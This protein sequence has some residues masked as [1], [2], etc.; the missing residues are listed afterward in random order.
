MKK[1]GAT[2]MLILLLAAGCSQTARQK[3]EVSQQGTF[4][5]V[6]EQGSS[7]GA[8]LQQ[9]ESIAETAKE[10]R[11]DYKG[12]EINGIETSDC[13]NL[14]Y[15]YARYLAL[16]QLVGIEGPPEDG[17]LVI[18]VE[19]RNSDSTLKGMTAAVKDVYREYNIPL[20][21]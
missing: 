9:S 14:G 20:E 7:A 8:T 19:C 6:S 11:D 4:S 1:F 21:E 5:D 13:Y 12:R 17:D 16:S 15:R 3:T 10:D 18:P 2:V